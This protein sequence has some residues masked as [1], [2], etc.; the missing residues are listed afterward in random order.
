MADQLALEE[1]MLSEGK[2]RFLVQVEKARAQ[3]REASTGY[4]VSLLRDTVH[5]VAAEI[6][7]VITEAVMGKSGGNYK[8][9][10]YLMEVDAE[11]AAAL[12]LRVC[13]NN[14]SKPRRL[15]SV[16]IE[17]GSNIEDEVIMQ[18]F[19]ERSAKDY[20]T[21]IEKIEGGSTTGHYRRSVARR[22]AKQAGVTLKWDQDI[23]HKLGMFLINLMEPMGL[24][25]AVTYFKGGSFKSVQELAPTPKV[26]EVI[27]QRSEVLAYLSPSY[28]PTIVPPKPW[29]GPKDGGYWSG[30]AHRVRFVISGKRR[31]QPA[32]VYEAI[33]AIQETAWVVDRKMLAVIEELFDTGMKAEGIPSAEPEKPGPRPLGLNEEETKAWMKA[34]A[35]KWKEHRQITSK[36]KA[37]SDVLTVARKMAPYEAIYFPH[38]LD[39][40]GRAYPI[41]MFLN[42]QGNDYVKSL[43]RFSKGLPIE[44]DEARMWL[45]VHG[46]NS[47]G[48][49]KVSFAKRI[50]W[51]QD[52][53]QMILLCANDP[54]GAGFRHWNNK[55]VDKPFC[56]LAWCFEWAALLDAEAKGEVFLSSV[57]VGLD[58]SCNGIQH[59][60]AALRDLEGGRAV[61]LLPG[62]EPADIYQTVADKASLIL[63]ELLALPKGSTIRDPFLAELVSK[64]EAEKVN[65]EGAVVKGKT[66]WRTYCQ[67]WLSFGLNRKITKRSVMCLPYGIGQRSSMAYILEGLQEVVEAKGKNPFFKSEEEDG[68][69]RAALFLQPVV[70]AAIT[71]TVVA[72]RSAMDWIKCYTKLVLENNQA[73]SWITPDG[74]L[75]EQRYMNMA[76]RRIDTTLFGSV[77][78]HTLQTETQEINKREHLNGVAPNWVHS[79]DAT[80]MRLAVLEGKDAG[81]TSFAM[82][83]DSFGTHAANTHLFSHLIR[84]S[85]VNMYEGSDPIA[86]FAVSMTSRCAPDALRPNL[87]ARGTLDLSNVL[88][89]D[90]F[91]A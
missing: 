31:D 35:E 47:Y 44:T 61:N 64:W 2:R 58:G 45:A 40:R 37:L 10:P 74:F 4:G 63:S 54:L 57:P 36:R 1:W 21:T 28:L 22:F 69:F 23:K 25:E 73:P 5:H 62:D 33:N 72:A 85:F 49:D 78:K 38:Q 8:A 65:D 41:P 51:V 15:Q 7:R 81:L 77:V 11:V 24:F 12:A 46:A 30:M 26:L 34:A 6:T 86:M 75:I 76:G 89:S 91:F 82:V 42:P 71:A 56:F 39:F 70:W 19:K 29:T 80:A 79:M 14:I 17:I 83:H 53:E 9:I 32:A 66:D 52:N 16:A 67:Q 3:G 88:E 43:L 55:A 18:Q 60:S 87:P 48:V 50:Q 90:Y 13:L 59:Y 84:E 27:R 20:A 68:L